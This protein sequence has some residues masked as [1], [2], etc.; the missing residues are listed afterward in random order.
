MTL[1]EKITSEL[2]DAADDSDK[3]EAVFARHAHSKEPLYS[4]LA[5]A[6]ATLQERLK[7]LAEQERESQVRHQEQQ[8]KVEGVRK[9][10]PNEPRP[11]S[12]RSSAWSMSG[13]PR[14][15]N[16]PHWTAS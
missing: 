13:R 16:W 6:T 7:A 1:T 8:Q 9:R 14:A 5:K 11:P 12:K 3:I 4:A 10:L 2:L 15:R